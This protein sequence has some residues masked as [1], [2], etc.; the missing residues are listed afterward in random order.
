MNIYQ[1][2]VLSCALIIS[3]V[4]N[5]YARTDHFEYNYP[6][7]VKMYN[8]GQYEEVISSTKD[9]V[10]RLQ[11]GY[12][13]FNEKVAAINLMGKAYLRTGKSD[14]AREA[15][16]I[17]NDYCTK[18]YARGS[19]DCNESQNALF[20]LKNNKRINL[21]D[22]DIR[23]I[24]WVEVDST[25]V[26]YQKG[27]LIKGGNTVIVPLGYSNKSDIDN[28]NKSCKIKIDCKRPKTNIQVSGSSEDNSFVGRLLSH[29]STLND[30]VRGVCYSKH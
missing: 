6:K 5:S 24:K 15:F 4:S 7:A 1:F 18:T 20:K 28:I 2:F 30:L 27:K 22:S 3:S 11:G 25:I 26:Y 21:D 16:E 29:E 23:W 13:K 12:N 19:N 9:M 8:N 17:A 10:Y 14:Q